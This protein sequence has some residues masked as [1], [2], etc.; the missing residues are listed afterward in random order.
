MSALILFKSLLYAQRGARLLAQGGI[1]A[2]V[3]KAPRGTED[4]GC[5]YGVRLSQGRLRPALRL[6][7]EKNM[8]RGRVFLID[9]DGTYREAAL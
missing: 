9:G 4:R 8:S 2:T 6:L 7:E 3:V 5:T 1:P